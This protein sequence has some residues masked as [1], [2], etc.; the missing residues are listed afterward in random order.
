MKRALS[1]LLQ[2]VLLL[3]AFLLGSFAPI[4]HMLPMERVETSPAR[5]FV[6]DGVFLLLAVYLLLLVVEALLGRL[7]RSAPTTTLALLLALAL[8]LAMKFPFMGR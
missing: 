4:F 7:R 5:Y 2:L 6:L 8:G 1:V 3:I